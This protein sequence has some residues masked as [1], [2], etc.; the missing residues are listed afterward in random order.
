MSG[1][2]TFVRAEILDNLCARGLIDYIDVA[3]STLAV[4]I[5]LPSSTTY[6]MWIIRRRST[7]RRYRYKLAVIQSGSERPIWLLTLE[8]L[9]D[10]QNG[11]LKLLNAR[12]DRCP[13]FPP[14][15]RAPHT[16]SSACPSGVG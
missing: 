6:G 14:L 12:I 8:H 16:H 5:L 11:F 2:R 15:S 7:Q 1:C 4:T 3:R 13:R 9:S 10:P